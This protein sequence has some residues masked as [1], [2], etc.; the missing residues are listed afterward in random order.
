MAKQMKRIHPDCGA[1]TEPKRCSAVRLIQSWDMPKF[2]RIGAALAAQLAPA[3][4]ASIVK[5][6]PMSKL[7]V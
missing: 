6:V 3:H 5:S 2:V 1:E 4:L 7:F